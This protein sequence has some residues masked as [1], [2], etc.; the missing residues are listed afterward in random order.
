MNK[1]LLIPVLAFV[2]ATSCSAAK[3]SSAY[4]SVAEATAARPDFPMAG[5]YVSTDWKTA[6]QA[7]MLHD[8]SFL[9]AEYIG[10]LP[11]AGWNRSAI[12]S[13]VKKADELKTMLAGYTKTERTSPTLGK[14]QP[15]DAAI[16]FPDDFPNVKN[17]ILMAG[18]KTEKKPQLLP[19][20][21]GIYAAL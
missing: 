18:D 1:I 7:S 19:H 11:R 3:D 8:G 9:V 20:A 10:G 5:E 21:S 13:S 4:L 6:L 16:K 14:T 12:T 15:E 17:G 2:V